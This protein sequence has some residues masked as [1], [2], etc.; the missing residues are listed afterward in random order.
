MVQPSKVVAITGASG[1]VGSRLLRQLEE[2]NLEKLVGIDT[3]PPP[4]PIHNIAVYKRDVEGSI[5][6]ILRRHR[7]TTLV[8]LA[9]SKQLG[10]Y[11]REIRE[12]REQNRKL[13]DRVLDSCLRAGVS[14]I[15]YLSSHA[16]YG[17]R[18]DNPVPLTERAPL[19]VSPD[20]PYGYDN[21]L[22]DQT[23]DTFAEE[24]QQVKVAVLRCSQV[25]GPGADS[26]L[27]NLFLQ[28]RPL[29]I[30]GFDPPFQFFHEDDLAR[31]LTIFIKQELS[32]VFNVAGDGVAF[33]REVA[34][35]ISGRI[36][37][38]PKF[39]AYPLVNLSWALGLQRTRTTADLDVLRYPSLLSTGK[40]EQA[41]GYRPRY[42]S[43]ETV[44]SFV[45][46]VLP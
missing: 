8:H 42:N 5:E 36:A 12:V 40:L 43:L 29:G 35:M 27:F 7:V 31:V 25:L 3:R 20:F 46:S 30:R 28:S 1:Y 45:N 13:L 32:G 19:L 11:R 17:A 41:T 9:F 4:L 14:Q 2:E 6:D 33:L 23:L 21:F 10:R 38:L 44:T 26:A 39:L 34:E 24:N 22:A 16:V 15:I 37:R 18:W